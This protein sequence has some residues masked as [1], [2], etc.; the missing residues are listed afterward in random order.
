M[1]GNIRSF[2]AYMTFTTQL[3]IKKDKPVSTIKHGGG[4]VIL[5]LKGIM[6]TAPKMSLCMALPTHKPH[7]CSFLFFNFILS[8]PK[9]VCC[10]F[11]RVALNICHIKSRKCSEIIY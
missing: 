2:S 9:R 4:S 11:K 8:P 10:F 3:K 6:G 5:K 7:H 1:L